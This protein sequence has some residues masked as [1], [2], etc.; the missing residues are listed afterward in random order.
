MCSKVELVG[1][2][3]LKDLENCVEIV[4]V[5]ILILDICVYLFV[6]KVHFNLFVN[7][8]APWFYV[9]QRHSSRLC[10]NGNFFL[11]FPML[12]GRCGPQ[13][14]HISEPGMV[15][16]PRSLEFLH[17]CSRG[18]LCLSHK[19]LAFWPCH[20]ISRAFLVM[21]GYYISN[22]K[23]YYWLYYVFGECFWLGKGNQRK[24]WMVCGT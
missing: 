10:T 14:A 18:D 22:K 21:A 24:Q 13:F 6:S 20:A 2:L 1:S 15:F 16:L 11:L 7:E 23:H 4:F 12:K 3:Q 17:L 19:T 9:H 8:D 5:L